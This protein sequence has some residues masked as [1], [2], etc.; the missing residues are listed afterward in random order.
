L[1]LN[2]GKKAFLTLFF[3]LLK[4]SP[5]IVMGECGFRDKPIEIARFLI[6]IDHAQGD[7]SKVAGESPD[8]KGEYW[9]CK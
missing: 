9:V 8:F 2:A 7:S 1:N 4:R 3:R 5:K 6:Y